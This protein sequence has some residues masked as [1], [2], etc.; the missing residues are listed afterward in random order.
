M[1]NWSGDTYKKI[2]RATSYQRKN[3]L[4][5]RYFF[6]LL[7][8]VMLFVSDKSKRILTICSNLFRGCF[9]YENTIWTSDSEALKTNKKCGSIKLF[10]LITKQTSP[11]FIIVTVQVLLYCSTVATKIP[12]F[13]T[14]GNLSFRAPKLFKKLSFIQNVTPS[15]FLPV[16]RIDYFFV[17]MLNMWILQILL[18][19]FHALGYIDPNSVKNHPTRKHLYSKSIL[20]LDE[21]VVLIHTFC[22]TLCLVWLRNNVN[23]TNSMS[24]ETS[25]QVIWYHCLDRLHCATNDGCNGFRTLSSVKNRHRSLNLCCRGP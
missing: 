4:E 3:C 1:V 23:R 21:Y 17:Y 19:F 24:S 12:G 2:N 25:C 15:F 13:L 16:R 14:V 6:F 5:L 11:M 9:Q 7:L 18:R 10:S 20:A 8:E 22:L